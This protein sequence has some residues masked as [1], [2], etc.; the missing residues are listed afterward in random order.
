VLGV[1]V[2]IGG[3]VVFTASLHLP[4]AL[5]YTALFRSAPSSALAAAGLAIVTAWTSFVAATAEYADERAFYALT[6]AV[7]W[8]IVLATAAAAGSTIDA[9]ARRHAADTHRLARGSE[10]AGRRSRR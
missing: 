8:A 3:S 9:R 4:L 6:N 10:R 1:T 5:A 7:L 2:G